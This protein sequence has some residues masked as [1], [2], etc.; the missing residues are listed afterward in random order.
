MS[1]FSKLGKTKVFAFQAKS[2]V[3]ISITTVVNDDDNNNNNNSQDGN[4]Y[5]IRME[6]ASSNGGPSFHQHAESVEL[7]KKGRPRNDIQPRVTRK[8]EN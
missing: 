5:G 4:E 6:L 8:K 7:A 2:H 3:F 1:Q